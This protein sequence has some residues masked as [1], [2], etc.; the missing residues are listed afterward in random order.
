ME[1]PNIDELL[2]DIFTADVGNLEGSELNLLLDKMSICEVAIE[3]LLWGDTHREYYRSFTGL[4]IKHL[5]K[6]DG[7]KCVYCGSEATEIDHVIPYVLYGPTIVA[8]AVC[9]CS[10]C[11]QRKGGNLD[12]DFLTRGLY[13]LFRHNEKMTWIEFFNPHYREFDYSRQRGHSWSK[14]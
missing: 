9:C 10:D 13:W 11:N 6:R 1:K 3:L 2:L 4:Q 8:N 7:G 12:I 14:A 5:M